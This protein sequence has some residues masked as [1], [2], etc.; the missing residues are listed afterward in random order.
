MNKAVLPEVEIVDY[1]C[2]KT[3]LALSWFRNMGLSVDEK[4]GAP[5]GN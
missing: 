2:E 1:A 3:A 5:L 4:E